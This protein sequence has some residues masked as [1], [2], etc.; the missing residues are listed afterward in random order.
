M[1]IEHSM[2]ALMTP[3]DIGEMQ[4]GEVKE[5]VQAVMAKLDETP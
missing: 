2:G 4:I 3:Y 1:I 5:N